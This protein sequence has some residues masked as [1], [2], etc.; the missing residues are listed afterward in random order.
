MKTR[1]GDK[2]IKDVKSFL[3]L[4]ESSTGVQEGWKHLQ[5]DEDLTGL[6]SIPWTGITLEL[7]DFSA[8]NVELNDKT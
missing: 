1:V 5:M 6:P 7:K 8:V 2:S 4:F 3:F